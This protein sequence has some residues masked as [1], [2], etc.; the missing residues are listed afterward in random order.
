[1]YINNWKKFGYDIWISFRFRKIRW[2]CSVHLYR[3]TWV[4]RS[5]HMNLN[6]VRRV[7]SVR[8]TEE[9]RNLFSVKIF[10]LSCICQNNFKN[11][12]ILKSLISSRK[13]SHVVDCVSV[14]PC[15]LMWH[16]WQWN[17]GWQLDL[18][19]RY[20]MSLTVENIQ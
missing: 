9:S 15:Y 12:V 3:C 1:M 7:F 17:F 5:L 2:K 19:F 16:L 8:I 11:I 10:K 4:F 18:C 6:D 14:Y 20:L 13:A